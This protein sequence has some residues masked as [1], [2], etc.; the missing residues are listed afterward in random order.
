MTSLSEGG[1]QGEICGGKKGGGGFFLSGGGGGGGSPWRR[2]TFWKGGGR[3]KERRESASSSTE[4]EK[5]REGVS[6]S[7]EGGKVRIGG[8]DN[9]VNFY[10]GRKNERIFSL[11]RGAGKYKRREKEGEKKKNRFWGGGGKKRPFFFTGGEKPGETQIREGERGLGFA[12]ANIRKKEKKN[13]Y[14]STFIQAGGGN[15]KGTWERRGSNLCIRIR[16]GEGKGG[17]YQWPA[18]GQMGGK[19]TNS[20]AKEMEEGGGRGEVC[21]KM[22]KR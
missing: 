4:E 3:G 13:S 19:K 10:S 9:P 22:L 15:R 11:L 12:G 6:Q 16:K 14:Y 18:K 21:K 7:T 8:K 1:G 5:K 20:P 2:S 17:T